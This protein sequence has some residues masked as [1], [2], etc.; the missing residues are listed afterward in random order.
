[1]NYDGL[2]SGGGSTL[3]ISGQTTFAAG[4]SAN[5]DQLLVDGSLLGSFGSGYAFR[6]GIY[7][8]GVN[9]T[10]YADYNTC[11]IVPEGNRMKDA[12]DPPKAVPDSPGQEREWLDSIKLPK[13]A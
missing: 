12:G 6:V 5:V 10:L 11:N 4:S 8:Q 9:G 2:A 7:F 1:M 13:T 3:E